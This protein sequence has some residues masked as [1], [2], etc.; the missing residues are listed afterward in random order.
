MTINNGIEEN[1]KLKKIRRLP[2]PGEVYV[3]KND[4]VLSNTLIAKGTVRNPEIIEI[5][6]DQKLDVD[7]DEVKNYLLKKV[8][9]L[10]NKDEVIAIRR[11]FFG[12]STKIC[13]SPITGII[14]S[15]T[16]RSS[17]MLIRGTP[18]P[19][20]VKAHIPGKVTDVIPLEGASIECKASILH[21]VFGVGG[22]TQ[23]P[24]VV[25]CNND[26][27]LTEDKITNDHKGK[28]LVAGSGLTLEILKKALSKEVAGIIVGGVDEEDLSH[29]I[30]HEIGLGIT[31]SENSKITI[32]LTEGFGVNPIKE[33]TYNF[34]SNYA[35]KLACIDGTTQIRSRM[36]KPEIIIPL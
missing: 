28:I 29:F 36:L 13:R 16:D 3:K 17:R 35:G 7:S 15:Y 26:E 30:G 18:I 4:K 21:G 25:V 19:V 31:G 5:R 12:R 20:E 8:G 1:V 22:E 34:L 23:G 2:I 9:D 33:M 32:I 27:F 6:I 11:T 14:E 10:V 24:L